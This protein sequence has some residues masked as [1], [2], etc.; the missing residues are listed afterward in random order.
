MKKEKLNFNRFYL[1]I[2]A[3]ENIGVI[4]HAFQKRGVKKIFGW[5]ILMLNI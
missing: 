2:S 3:G 1:F 5:M 4:F